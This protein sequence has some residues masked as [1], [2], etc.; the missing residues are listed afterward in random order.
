MFGIQRLPFTASMVTT[1]ACHILYKTLI[2][3]FVTDI[4]IRLFGTQR[5]GNM[6]LTL[7]WDESTESLRSAARRRR[8][9]GSI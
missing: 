9:A 4:A 2:G 6:G 5:D 7:D 1:F 8:I 3:T